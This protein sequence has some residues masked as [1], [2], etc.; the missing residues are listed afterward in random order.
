[1]HSNRRVQRR[2]HRTEL[3]PGLPDQL[4]PAQVT[5]AIKWTG[6][7]SARGPDGLAYD[8]L[9]HLRPLGIRA[10]CSLFNQS[11]RL[12]AI[13]YLWKLS[14]IVPLLK[15][16]K[17]PNLPMSYRP[18]SLLCTPSKILER[19]VLTK[20]NPSVSSR[21][22]SSQHGFRPLHSTC[23]LHSSLSQSILDSLN[24]SKP[25]S[26]SLVAAMDISKVLDTVPRNVLMSKILHTNLH[27]NYERWLAYFIAGRQSRVSYNGT[28]S[29]TRLFPNGVPQGAVLSPNLFN[30]FLYD[31][32]SPTSVGVT[33]QS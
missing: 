25:A 6:S 15:S 1:V 5:E 8:H 7:S 22:S 26:R 27:P 19:L 2:L 28:L 31:L 24:C 16:D 32:H 11:I 3:D 33:I 23:T 12:N 29:K 20:I 4:S 9:R 14:T 13:P 30:L 21:L 18:I 17:T 10:L